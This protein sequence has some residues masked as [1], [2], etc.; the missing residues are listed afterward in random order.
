M[1]F[2]EAWM[3]AKSV[4]GL[5]HLNHYHIQFNQVTTILSDF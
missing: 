4:P 3:M 5:T 2:I 1:Q